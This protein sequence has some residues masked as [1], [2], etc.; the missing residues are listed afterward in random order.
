MHAP[1]DPNVGTEELERGMRAGRAVDILK[2]GLIAVA[3]LLVFNSDGLAKWTQTLPSSATNAWLAE[4][5][6]G[7]H[8]LMTRLGPA[9]LF[10]RLR[11]RWRID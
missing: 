11:E 8:Q 3:L 6:D 10:D 2:I 5:A 9:A 4:Q 7:W 1:K